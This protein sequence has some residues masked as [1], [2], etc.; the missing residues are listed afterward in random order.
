MS[1]RI[2]YWDFFGPRAAQIAA[3]HRK[4]VDEFLAREAIPGCETGLETAG[5]NHHA[6]WCKA[7]PEAWEVILSALKPKRV[8][9]AE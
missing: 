2:Y 9:Q 1:A 5:G 3:H 6:A 8:R 4:H 7:P